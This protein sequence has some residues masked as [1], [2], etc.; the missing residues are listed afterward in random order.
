MIFFQKTIEKNNGLCY[1]YNRL[2]VGKGGER[3]NLNQ[4]NYFVT[5]AH[6]EHYTKAAE[7]LSITQPSLSHAISMLE[8]ELQTPLFEKRGRNVALTK[9]GKIFLEYVE[10]ALHTLESGIKK[11]RALTGETSGVIDLAYIFTLGTEFVPGLVSAFIREHEGWDIK[12]QFTVGN[13][14]DI[15]QGLKDEKYDIAF[16][17][18][19]ENETE[20]EFIP[21]GKEKLVIV[22]PKGHPLADRKAVRLEDTLA[23]PYVYFTKNS[24]LRTTID[25]LF[26]KTGESPQIAYEI[27]ED[28]SMA[29]LVAQNFGIAIMPEVPILKNLNV[30]VLDIASPS[31]DR[32]IYMARLKNRYMTPVSREFTHYVQRNCG[33]GKRI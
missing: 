7:K 11:T 33:A 12:F 4:L 22:V 32:F 27:V 3:M 9:Y 6:M 20:I 29:G 17:S 24:G 31:Y 30:E 15:I 13:T 5:L 18:R 8:T 2:D 19:K 14:S 28:G 1:V 26:A 21:V 25:N 16:C 23:Y 10:E